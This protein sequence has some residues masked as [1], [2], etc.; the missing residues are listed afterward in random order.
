[1]ID[2]GLNRR[3]DPTKT[4]LE[5]AHQDSL[6]ARRL[7]ENEDFKWWKQRLEAAVEVQKDKLVW[8][9]KQ[10]PS[11]FVSQCGMIQGIVRVY[12]ELETMADNL[13]SVTSQL[14]EHDRRNK[15]RPVA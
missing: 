7:L 6:R 11:R 10:E 15:E 3:P 13:E 14:E 5:E 2:L 8:A 12:R 4:Q 9:K 1:M